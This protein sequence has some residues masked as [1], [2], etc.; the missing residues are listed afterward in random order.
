MH[1][2]SSIFS[3][4]LRKI[5]SVVLLV[6]L[7][8]GGIAY[9]TKV[10]MRDSSGY[11]YRPFFKEDT[12]YDI[13]FFGTSH[14]INGIF[15][16][17][18]WNDYGITS[19]NFGGHANSLGAAYWSMVNAVKY[20]KPKIAVLD[21]LGAGSNSAAMDISYAHLSF[22]AFPLSPT[23]ISTAKDIFSAD[24]GA[25]T[26]LIFPLSVYH[27]RWNELTAD[28]L[29]AGFG[30][31]SSYNVEKGAESRIAVAIPNETSR[32]S[33]FSRATDDSVGLQ[34]I[35]K[36]I[37][38]CN[39]HDI[40]PVII[41]IPF[42]A[43]EGDQKWANAAIHLADTNGAGYINYPYLNLVDYD[44]DCYDSG[45][46]LNPSGARKVTDYLGQ[47][48]TSHYDLTDHRTDETY[49]CWHDDY[50]SYHNFL[51]NNIRNNDDYKVTL[52]LLNNEDFKAT[53]EITKDY[54][55]DE[56]EQKLIDQLGSSLKQRTVGRVMTEG[57]QKGTLKLTIYDTDTNGI[58]ATKV[59]QKTDSLNLIKD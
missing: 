30:R 43:N 40:E 52:M 50:D 47:Y 5:L 11:K 53:L 20:H 24:K 12:E 55:P 36:F 1:Q 15:P 26:E 48:L 14:V 33:R 16:M 29:K 27:N 59:Y 35:Q 41:N 44:T 51:I 54:E 25:Q 56:V 22:D 2:V 18:L 4:K 34:Y 49:A 21:V 38:Y 31:Y 8:L 39:E 13:L 6:A 19:Y 58:V 10:T 32:I 3:S 37:D 17:Q 57:G 7:L 23:K 46:H 9:L 28:M 45:S 42:P